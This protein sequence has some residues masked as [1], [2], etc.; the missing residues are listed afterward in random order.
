M[1]TS[2]HKIETNGASDLEKWH[3]RL[4]T[5]KTSTKS[6]FSLQTW[7]SFHQLREGRKRGDPIDRRE[8]CRHLRDGCPAWVSG[9]G[10]GPPTRGQD[11][12]GQWHGHEGCDAGGG[13]PLSLVSPGHHQPHRTVQEGRVRSDCLASTGRL[14]LYQVSQ[15]ILHLTRTLFSTATWFQGS[16]YSICSQTQ[17]IYFLPTKWKVYSSERFSPNFLVKDE[18]FA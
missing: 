18:F 15:N 14:I 4:T 1:V 12:Q 7:P 16:T 3:D 5:S 6:M 17:G 8:R 11:P 9:R 10:S 13:R 2:K